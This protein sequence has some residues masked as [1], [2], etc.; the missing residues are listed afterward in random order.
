VVTVEKNAKYHSNQEVTNPYIVTNV[1]QTT[2]HKTVEALDLV[3]DLV[4]VEVLGLVEA[5]EEKEKCILQLVVTVATNVKYH[6]NQKR[7][8]PYI[9]TNVF[10]ITNLNVRNHI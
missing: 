1:F 6:S 2:S 8:D 10:R 9:V 3:E 4:M 5:Q 7:T